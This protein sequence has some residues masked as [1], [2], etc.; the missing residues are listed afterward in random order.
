MEHYEFYTY[1]QPRTRA[2]VYR[3]IASEFFENEEDALNWCRDK[4]PKEWMQGVE[5]RVRP[6]SE[7]MLTL[8]LDF[9]PSE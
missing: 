5:I 3:K 6:A 1:T 4:Y 9:D 8:D 2:C 7:V